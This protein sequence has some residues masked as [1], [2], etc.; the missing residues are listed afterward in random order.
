M[1]PHAAAGAE[2]VPAAVRA[3]LLL[4][5]AV[6]AGACAPGPVKWPDGLERD[7]VLLYR[8]DRGGIGS[9]PPWAIP[10]GMPAGS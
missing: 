5:L 9:F 10:S 8:N 7:R 4:G 2:P 3:R 6:V 1:G